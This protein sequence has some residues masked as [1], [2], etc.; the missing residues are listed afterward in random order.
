M[1]IAIA[2]K[3]KVT[4]ISTSP[5]AAALTTNAWSGLETQLNI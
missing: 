4:M 5:A 1:T 2:F 3:D